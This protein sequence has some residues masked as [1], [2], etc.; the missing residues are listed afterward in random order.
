[1]KLLS[2]YT[3]S[4]MEVTV[5]VE[6]VASV[7]GAIGGWEAI[8]YLLNRK[9]NQRIAEA[10]ADSVE[11]STLKETIE[12]LQCQFKQMVENDA[13]KEQRFTEQTQRL[14][15]TQDREHKLMQEKAK[16]ELELQTYRCVVKK[17]PNR[18]PKNGY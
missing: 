6:I 12:F 3:A 15:E 5:I 14:R 7:I 8:K 18:E 17:C 9:T 4:K 16:L 1:M 2:N 13:A 10:Q 11:F